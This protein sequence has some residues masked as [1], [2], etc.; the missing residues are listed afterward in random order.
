MHFK[1]AERIVEHVGI[2]D[3]SDG[4]LV[5]LGGGRGSETG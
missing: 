3:G 1:R 2:S 5:D 4:C